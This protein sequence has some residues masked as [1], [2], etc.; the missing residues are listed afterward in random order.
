MLRYKIK[1]RTPI[2]YA[3]IANYIPCGEANKKK[4]AWR[5]IDAQNTF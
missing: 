5:I 3:A 4:H 2:V 1:K